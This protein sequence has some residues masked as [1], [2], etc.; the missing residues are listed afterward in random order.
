MSLGDQSSVPG[1][2]QPPAGVAGYAPAASDVCGGDKAAVEI[3]VVVPLFNESEN[4]VALARRV[5]E[6]FAKEPRVLELVLVDDGST[7]GTWGQM[8]AARQSDGRVRA[9]RHLRRAG[10]SAALWTGFRAA[11]GPIICTLDGDLQND[12]ADLI[13]MLPLLGESDL[14]CGVR[15][16]R[17]DS[18]LRRV[19]TAVAR[20]ARR[21]VLGV[22][23]QDTGCNLR[24]FKR[25]VLEKL[26]LFDGLHRFMP[27]VAQAGGA[28]VREVPVSHQPRY[29]G[30][31]KYGVWNRLGRGIF[32]LAAIAWYRRRQIGSVETTEYRDEAERIPGPRATRP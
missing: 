6:S 29:A 24:V 26:F 32:D 14:V 18:L 15:V 16:N 2:R 19:S 4:V 31:S 11:R 22:D 23:F 7:D 28:V 30:K 5:F 13:R 10:Q 1:P 3:S 25:E 17:Q 8:L 9:L 21:T 20:W 27:I 12:P